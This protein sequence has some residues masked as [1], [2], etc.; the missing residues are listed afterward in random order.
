M[1]RGIPIVRRSPL[2]LSPRDQAK[3]DIGTNR[4]SKSFV[5]K[6]TAKRA[7][8]V[9]VRSV[10]E[11][12]REPQR[13]RAE[14][15]APAGMKQRAS[16]ALRASGDTAR[17]K[18]QEAT[19]AAKNI[20][21]DTAEKLQDQAREQ[22]RTGADFVDKFAGNLRE[23]ARAPFAARGIS[24]VAEYVEDVTEKIRNGSFRDL[25]DNATDSAKRRPV[26]F[27]GVTVLAGFAAVRAFKASGHSSSSRAA[28][29]SITDRV[30]EGMAR[31]RENLSK[32][33]SPLPD[34]A[35]LERARSSLSDIFERQPL[36]LGA[37]GLAVGAA[38]AGAFQTSEIENEWV[39]ELSDTV[40]EDP[41]PR[42]EAVA[43][44][45]MLGV[46]ALRSEISDAGAESIDRL[47]QTGKEAL[48]AARE[49]T[50]GGPVDRT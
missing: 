38:V 40:T 26:A 37:I 2:G 20:A 46:D 6:H 34:R 36:V 25:V 50:K 5:V 28:A 43:Q 33:G 35:A 48:D 3:W 18:F 10:E 1:S 14:L 49:T 9:M 47:K 19:E 42:S 30:D 24:S 13:S 4:Y 17:D 45:R 11:L 16:E 32:M 15:A 12:G 29:D 27:L 31:A 23:A 44:R 22:Q 21:S 7:L 41:N 39:G 8:T